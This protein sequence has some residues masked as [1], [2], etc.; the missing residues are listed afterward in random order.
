MPGKF[1]IMRAVRKGLNSLKVTKDKSYTEWTKAVKTELCKIGRRVGYK[2]CVSGVV[3]FPPRKTVHFESEFLG[4]DHLPAA[5][6]RLKQGPNFA[7]FQVAIVDAVG[8]EAFPYADEGIDMMS[9]A[10]RPRQLRKNIRK[11]TDNT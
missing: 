7:C 1:E 5:Q 2:V 6:S 4:S 9:V 10:S 3:T 11:P 8:I